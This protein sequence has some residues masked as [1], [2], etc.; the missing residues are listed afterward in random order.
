MRSRQDI[1]KQFKLLKQAYEKIKPKLGIESG[2][3]SAAF[4]AM[5]KQ[6]D[7]NKINEMHESLFKLT[8]KVPLYNQEYNAIRAHFWSQ[9]GPLD[10]KWQELFSEDY[11]YK[12]LY[13]D[14]INRQGAI[15]E[16][17]EKYCRL[18]ADYQRSNHG[19]AKVNI[20]NR[21]IAMKNKI[22]NLI[23]IH[24]MDYQK[25]AKRIADVELMR[26]R[27]VLISLCKRLHGTLNGDS[28]SDVNSMMKHI[29]DNHADGLN[30]TDI[31]AAQ[32]KIKAAMLRRL[33]G[34]E[35]DIEV[36]LISWNM[37]IYGKKYQNDADQKR[38]EAMVKGIRESQRIL[39][40]STVV[41]AD[42]EKAAGWLVAHKELD[43]EF[44]LLSARSDVSRVKKNIEREISLG[45]DVVKNE[46]TYH[47]LALFEEHLGSGKVNLASIAALKNQ[48]KSVGMQGN[49]GLN[50]NKTLADLS[51]IQ[52]VASDYIARCRREVPAA[53]SKVSMALNEV[54]ERQR[55][56]REV[57]QSFSNYVVYPNFNLLHSAMKEALQEEARVLK[58]QLQKH[59]DKFAAQGHLV[60]LEYLEN[61]IA[62]LD[63][64]ARFQEIIKG[65]DEIRSDIK[66]PN[67]KVQG[68]FQKRSNPIEN[69]ERALEAASIMLNN[70]IN[71]DNKYGAGNVIV[72]SE[73]LEK[74]TKAR[75]V[76]NADKITNQVKSMLDNYIMHLQ[77]RMAALDSHKVANP[78]AKMEFLESCRKK[79]E[80]GKY[81]QQM[82]LLFIN[83]RE[84]DDEL[85]KPQVSSASKSPTVNNSD[86][87]IVSE[88]GGPAPKPVT[89]PV[90]MHKEAAREKLKTIQGNKPLKEGLINYLEQSR[91]CYSL[92]RDILG[93][94]NPAIQEH[95]FCHLA[96]ENYIRENVN[97][98]GIS[99]KQGPEMISKLEANQK[100]MQ[101][102]LLE[103][104]DKVY[105]QI[106]S[107]AKVEAKKQSQEFLMLDAARRELAIK[108]KNTKDNDNA[109]NI[110]ALVDVIHK[111]QDQHFPKPDP[112][113]AHIEPRRPYPRR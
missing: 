40:K 103:A 5:L 13:S 76:E 18:A 49:H 4:A 113:P 89:R 25:I 22:D 50:S 14:L 94:N 83:L 17:I 7:P 19:V 33:E 57:A 74:Y 73:L 90:T 26:N 93:P 43:A 63:K 9:M 39:K 71:F 66:S 91:E 107:M 29:V 98:K 24:N 112:N 97:E 61:Q 48:F 53:G 101:R 80:A 21:M 67:V 6:R 60:R 8:K 84:L 88:L 95:S 72:L 47:F 1:E 62:A 92:A 70:K 75:S 12:K 96:V 23:A 106:D 27:D 82:H 100:A 64:T 59:D 65:F 77:G 36:P 104:G 69:A 99:S 110:K 78:R 105:Q 52:Q 16:L 34:Y 108:M 31:D 68:G 35:R 87:S 111:I 102:A 42:F 51:F 38:Y 20:G 11:P 30:Q 10:N 58:E 41:L 86:A 45:N 32:D 109:A 81:D 15:K 44:E 37:E 54:V 85:S 2:A 46:A 79:L 55:F 3:E 56:F 28:Y